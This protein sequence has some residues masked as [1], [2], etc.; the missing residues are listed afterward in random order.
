MKLLLQSNG[1]FSGFYSKFILI[2]TEE[3]ISDIFIK[4]EFL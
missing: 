1:G 4:L 3:T 2:D